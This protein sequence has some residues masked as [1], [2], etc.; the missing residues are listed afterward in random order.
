[1]AYSNNFTS[2][3]KFVCP[4]IISYCILV[5]IG[6]VLLLACRA[7]HYAWREICMQLK[8]TILLLKFPPC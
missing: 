8:P 5:D 2:S 7:N 6:Q 1:M 4:V 3:L